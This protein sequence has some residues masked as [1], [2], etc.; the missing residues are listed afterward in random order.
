LPVHSVISST[1]VNHEPEAETQKTVITHKKKDWGHRKR[2]WGTIGRGQSET[3]PLRSVVDNVSLAK[4][5]DL[6]ESH[7]DEKA[8]HKS[9]SVRRTRSPDMHNHR[10]R[11][12][13]A[14]VRS[15]KVYSPQ[16]MLVILQ[17]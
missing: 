11:S 17:I 7:A 10:K 5:K 4:E 9:H 6:H 3:V 16:F 2:D 12:R 1:Q 13:E 15:T 14:D 8:F